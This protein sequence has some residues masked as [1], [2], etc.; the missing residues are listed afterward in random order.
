[1]NTMTILNRLTEFLRGPI[2]P[3]ATNAYIERFHV[4][5]AP[6][7]SEPI[8]LIYLPTPRGAGDGF[9]NL[10]VTGTDV[11]RYVI[12][13]F[14]VQGLKIQSL[15]KLEEGVF[16]DLRG[17]KVAQLQALL[18]APR[19]ELLEALYKAGAIRTM[20]KQ[21]IFALQKVDFEKMFE[22]AVARESK[23]AAAG[24]YCIISNEE[25]LMTGVWEKG[26][27]KHSI[28]MLGKEGMVDRWWRNRQTIKKEA[29]A[30]VKND[31]LDAFL[32][33]Q[34]DVYPPATGIAQAHV[35]MTPPATGIAQAHMLLT[36]P[37]E[38][39]ASFEDWLCPL[40][41]L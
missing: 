31:I 6:T 12:F 15:K 8:S 33:E 38:Q 20:K 29:V 22:D 27:V 39:M 19:S 32:K 7:R 9:P 2:K 23:R 3:A 41:M 4:P 21:K 17:L 16:S 11:L 18:E 37:A 26:E 28:Q 35:L 5:V 40:F 36:P 34:W 13:R 10:L 14:R 24:G 30:K 1:M 25:D